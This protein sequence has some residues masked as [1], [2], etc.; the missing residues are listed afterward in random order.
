MCLLNLIGEPKG[1]LLVLRIKGN[2]PVVGLLRLR[3]M[4]SPKSYFLIQGL[5]YRI[6]ISQNSTLSKIQRIAIVVEDI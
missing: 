4:Q 5:Q 1:L 3:L 6:L 2:V